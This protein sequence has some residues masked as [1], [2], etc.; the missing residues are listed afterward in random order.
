MEY[1]MVLLFPIYIVQAILVKTFAR[2]KS[3]IRWLYVIF[4][5]IASRIVMDLSAENKID[6]KSVV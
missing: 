1:H 4:R 5:K 6:R 3:L 2:Y